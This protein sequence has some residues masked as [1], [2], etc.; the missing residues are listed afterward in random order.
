[1][2]INQVKSPSVAFFIEPD[3]NIKLIGSFDKF[4]GTDFVNAGCFFPQSS[5]PQIDLL[6]I[7][8]SVGGALYD[9]GVMGHVTIDL[10]SFPN[11]EED[12]AHPFF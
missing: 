7:C 5:L 10:I 3:S 4:S 6:K 1:M 8:N 12:G 9:K 2:Q 11:H